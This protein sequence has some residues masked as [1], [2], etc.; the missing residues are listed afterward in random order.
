MSDQAWRRQARED[1][2]AAYTELKVDLLGELD[3]LNEQL[4]YLNGK[5]REVRAALAHVERRSTEPSLPSPLEARGVEV[6]EAG[7]E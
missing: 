5:A 2:R 1:L 3:D 4:E 7:H 6:E